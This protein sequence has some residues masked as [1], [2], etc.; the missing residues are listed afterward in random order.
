MRIQ[1]VSDLRGSSELDIDKT[2]PLSLQEA[3]EKYKNFRGKTAYFI[4][5]DKRGMLFG[6]AS[7]PGTFVIPENLYRVI[8]SPEEGKDVSVSEILKN[9][10]GN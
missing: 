6:L 4:C 2:R 10:T 8:G 5:S 7:N 3:T 9:L 1:Y